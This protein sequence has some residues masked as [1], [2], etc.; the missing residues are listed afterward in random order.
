MTRAQST[1][2]DRMACISFYAVCVAF[3]AFDI[4]LLFPQEREVY[5][6]ATPSSSLI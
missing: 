3:L 1:A 4:I 2:M 5:L 6:Q